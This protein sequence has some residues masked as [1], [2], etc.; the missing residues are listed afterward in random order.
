MHKTYARSTLK[1]KKK[2]NLSM[3][4]ECRNKAPP[5]AKTLFVFWVF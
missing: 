5:L 3:E 4:E 2:T 1:K